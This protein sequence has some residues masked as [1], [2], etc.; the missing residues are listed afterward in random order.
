MSPIHSRQKS[1]RPVEK[2]SEPQKTTGRGHQFLQRSGPGRRQCGRPRP[3]QPDGIESQGGAGG[4]DEDEKTMG[5]LDAETAAQT[6]IMAFP[7]GQFFGG[8]E[9]WNCVGMP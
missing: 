5:D 2:L 4:T 7:T 6:T 3:G 1:S 9:I 8:F